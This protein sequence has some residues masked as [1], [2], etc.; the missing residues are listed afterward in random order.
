MSS[1]LTPVYASGDR[2][3]SYEKS[4]RD[5][6]DSRLCC[7]NTQRQLQQWRQ[8]QRCGP[9][10]DVPSTQQRR[11]HSTS[12]VFCPFTAPPHSSNSTSAHCAGAA[13][14]AQPHLPSS[15]L[16]HK[17]TPAAV[18]PLLRFQPASSC[19]PCTLL[20]PATS[21]AV[22]FVANS[23]S[24][25]MFPAPP[26]S[27]GGSHLTAACRRAFTLCRLLNVIPNDPPWCVSGAACAP[28]CH[29]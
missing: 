12:A 29:E 3:G 18:I 4:G 7:G 14:G 19:S 5:P 27:Q 1:M 17:E 2:G 21:S 25:V 28:T 9:Y 13:R 20:M 11:S 16:C 22:C 15:S 24:Q 23:T 26:A 10:Q 8:R 6:G